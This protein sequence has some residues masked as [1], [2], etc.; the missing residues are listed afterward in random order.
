MLNVTPVFC[1]ETVMQKRKLDHELMTGFEV[2]M[3]LRS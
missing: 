1:P 2:F 3:R